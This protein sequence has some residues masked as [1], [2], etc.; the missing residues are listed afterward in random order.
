MIAWR[1]LVFFLSFI[2]LSPAFF[3]AENI[4][5]LHV[6][7]KSGQHR[8][9]G[10]DSTPSRVCMR[11][12]RFNIETSPSS[13][14]FRTNPQAWQGL[15]VWYSIWASILQSKAPQSTVEQAQRRLRFVY[16]RIQT[17]EAWGKPAERQSDSS[18]SV[19][20]QSSKHDFL[21]FHA[22]VLG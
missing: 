6:L 16:A 13:A 4:S 17:R 1:R 3:H 15:T 7:S 19:A 22:S 21:A 8:L 20:W 10:G 9:G 12:W 14:I 5:V 2:R 11:M 18:T